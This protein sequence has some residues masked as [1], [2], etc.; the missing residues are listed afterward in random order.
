MVE[1]NICKDHNM[2]CQEVTDLKKHI[3]DS[4]PI[5]DGKAS[6]KQVWSLISAFLVISMAVVGFLWN[7]Q[8]MI[9]DRLETY[10]Q[11]LTGISANGEVGILIRMDKKLDTAISKLEGTAN[12]LEGHLRQGHNGLKP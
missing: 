4:R 7:E 9:R 11:T 2:V 12:A 8:R 6:T 5:I 1:N 3:E 10:Q